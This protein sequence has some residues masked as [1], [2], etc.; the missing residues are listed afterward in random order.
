MLA[1]IATIALVSVDATDLDTCEL[2]EIGDDGAECVAVIGIATFVR[3][4]TLKAR[5]RRT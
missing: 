2:F 1:F 4:S 5:T 3:S